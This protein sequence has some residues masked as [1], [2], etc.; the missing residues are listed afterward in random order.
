ML[1]DYKFIKKQGKL[2]V[3]Y[4][5]NHG[6][7]SVID[8]NVDRFKSY[9][10]DPNGKYQQPDGSKCSEMFTGDPSP[11]DL[12]TF[13]REL[14]PKYRELFEGKVSPKLYT[15][16]I[17]T[18]LRDDREFTEPSSAEMPIH[19]ISV[20]SPE[21]KSIVMGDKE[22]SPEDI[23]WVQD[24]I[25]K[26]LND[27]PFFHTL[28]LSLPE[29]K[30]QY[31]NNE[32]DMLEFFLK[33]IVAKVP[34]LSGWNN[35]GYDWQYI[36]NRIKNYHP[37]LSMTS[38]SSAY[39]CTPKK[40]TDMKGNDFSV[41]MPLHTPIIDMMDVIDQ[42]DLSGLTAKES[43]S[44]DYIASETPGLE[45]HKVDYDGD[46]EQLYERDF[47]RYVYY[48]AV[49]SILVQLINYRYK[50]LDTMY[51]QALY[52][53]TKI[54][55]TF[56]KIAVS[57]A[58][59]WNDFYEH[60]YKIV[61]NK[62]WDA[63]RGRLLGAYVAKPIPGK[64]DFITCNDFASLY[65]STIITCNI[66]FENYI[67]HFYQ[68][69]VLNKY[70]NAPLTETGNPQY[71]VV[72]PVVYT[73]ANA[74]KKKKELEL[75]EFVGNFRDDKALEPYRKD[76]NYFVSVNGHIYKNDKDYSFKRIQAKLKAT[77]NISKYLGK[78]LDAKVMLDVEHI[79]KNMVPSNDPYADNLVQA[80]K[81]M[82][83]DI[84]SSQDLLAMNNDDLKEF[85]RV[86]AAEI[87]FYTCKEQAM[88][89]LG[90]SMYGGSSH[91]A[92]YW[93]NLNLARDITGEARN[94]TKTMEAHL[95]KFWDE[96]WVSM[97]D[98]H[99]KWGYEVDANK[100]Q[101][102]LNEGKHMITV[103]YGDTDSLYIS[104]ANLLSTIKGFDNMTMREKLDVIV[105]INTDFLNDHNKAY[106]DK[107]YGDRHAKSI[108]DFELETVALS[109][110][111]LNV[112]KRYCQILLWKDG[113]YFDADSLPLKVKGLE[114]TKSS[115]PKFVR[116]HLKKV[117]RSILESSETDMKKLWDLTNILV[118]KQRMEHAQAPLED[119]CANQGI[120]GY[121]KYISTDPTEKGTQ[122][123]LVD[124]KG[125]VIRFRSKAGAG[126][127][128]L[129][130]YN[131]IREAHNL[132]GD[133]IY[134]GKCKLYFA[135]AINRKEGPIPFAFQAKNYPKWGD[136]YAP[137]DRG[138]MFK[139]YFLDP[140]NRICGDSMNFK[141]FKLDGSKELTL[142]DFDEF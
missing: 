38:A 128:A 4:V 64:W 90:N 91:K 9:Y 25:T 78:Q 47:K 79:F 130:T 70:I 88:K 99:K 21:L 56:S 55:D 121:N 75:G 34:I 18:K 72:G 84:H 135:K 23:Q 27:L 50:T 20:V 3:S 60:G 104:Y 29:F 49:D 7:K 48:N 117:V 53:G 22:L 96:N 83:Y 24:Q 134:G 71:I 102:L 106:M 57:E 123:M 63:E 69:D 101:Q 124:Q 142:F 52:C 85:K 37:N 73:N 33:G 119:I 32:H 76:P 93:F 10:L 2:S 59:T 19:T 129:A 114:M 11:F 41:P 141:P 58:L 103:V 31:Y 115:Y 62:N 140:L 92:F 28:G 139:K 81:E 86:L 110:L 43:T 105:H 13:F 40:F 66:S 113:K 116:N 8:F 12:R 109:G 46:L 87:V 68:D 67:D 74:H 15:F 39:Q 65:P 118:Q 14:D 80:M 98:W 136:D 97:T 54:Q 61:Y 95:P 77:R 111:W 120:N 133:P 30:Y 51:M 36:T 44:L 122:T 137:C 108:H 5:N 131:A 100:V 45:V 112:K 82:G 127:K 107:Y 126:P 42:F 125:T 26:F 35:I 138:E 17:E 1:L 132:K 89:L 6:M 16:D 94:L